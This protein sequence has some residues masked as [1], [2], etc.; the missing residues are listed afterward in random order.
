MSGIAKATVTVG[1]LATIAGTAVLI[2]ARGSAAEILGAALLGLAGIAFTGLAFL[3]V[4]E[5]EDRERVRRR[6]S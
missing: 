4:G 3:L 6:E 2:L 1:V 5:S